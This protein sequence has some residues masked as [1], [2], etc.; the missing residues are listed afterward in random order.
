MAGVVSFVISISKSLNR[1]VL[2][3]KVFRR[4]LDY[5]VSLEGPAFVPPLAG[6]NLKVKAD[7]FTDL[8]P[9]VRS[10]GRAIS[11]TSPA[12][13]AGAPSNST[14]PSPERSNSVTLERLTP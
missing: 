2:I 3:F 4:P 12:D 7:L 9:L 10:K 5:Q 8:G 11:T 1:P 14:H 13:T 6:I